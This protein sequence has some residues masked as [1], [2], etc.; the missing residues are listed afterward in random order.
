ELTGQNVSAIARLDTGQALDSLE[1]EPEILAGIYDQ[2]AEERRLVKMNE[3]PKLLVQAVLAAEDKRFLEH[4]G[5]DLRGV[6][7]ALLANLRSRRVVQGGSTLTQQLIKNFFLS[8][9]RTVERKLTEAAMALLAEWHY[10]KLEIL[11]TYLNEIYLGQRGSRGLYGVWEG[12]QFYFGKEP[13]DLTIGE[14][15]M[16]AGLIRSPGRLSPGRNPVAAKRRR[17][18]VLRALVDGG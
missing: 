7:R 5:I 10:G 11:E 9:S 1:F 6:F 18:E 15:A 2:A 4:H 16:L 14:A 12:A 8:S 3:V 17:D 13:K